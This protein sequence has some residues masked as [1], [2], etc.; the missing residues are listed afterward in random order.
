MGRISM[1]PPFE[2]Y[3]FFLTICFEAY[4]KRPN[5]IMFQ[6]KELHKGLMAHVGTAQGPKLSD[7]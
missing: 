5:L 3:F 7:V 2:A 1:V 6:R 4:Y